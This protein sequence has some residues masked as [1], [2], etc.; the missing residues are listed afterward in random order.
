MATCKHCGFGESV[1]HG[2]VRGKQRYRCKHCG[3]HFVEGDGR[4]KESLVAKKAMAVVL[5]SL[6]KASFGMLGN[7]F[8][9]SRALAYRWIKEA[10]RRRFPSPRPQATL[11]KWNSTKCGTSSAQKNKLWIIKAVDRGTGRTVA[12]VTGGRDAKTFRRL[13]DKVKHLKS[14]VF[15]TDDWRPSLKSFLRSGISS[16]RRA[17]SLSS[18]TTAIP[19]TIWGE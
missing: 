1:K 6:A 18:A 11:R 10:R 3:L 5:Y 12:W 13:Y 7:V 4:V 2:R 19:G 15:Y 14:C 17:R 9:V 8:G 16:A